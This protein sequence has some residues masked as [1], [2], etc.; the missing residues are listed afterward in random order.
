MNK[1]WCY[2]VFLLFFLPLLCGIT[3]YNLNIFYLIKLYF[4][5]LLIKYLFKLKE[6]IF[7]MSFIYD[8]I[9]NILISK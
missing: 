7:R 2:I 6:F 8:L 3:N 5:Y 1:F 4:F 9:Y